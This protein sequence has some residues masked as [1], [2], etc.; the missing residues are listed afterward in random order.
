MLLPLSRRQRRAPPQLLPRPTTRPLCPKLGW[1]PPPLRVCSNG[2][3]PTVFWPCYVLFYIHGWHRCH[4]GNCVCTTTALCNRCKCIY[5]CIYVCMCSNFQNI[6]I[7]IFLKSFESLH[8]TV[9]CRKKK[10]PECEGEESRETTLHYH[11]YH[12]VRV[13]LVG[14]FPS[15]S[16]FSISLRYYLVPLYPKLPYL[17]YIYFL[18]A[19]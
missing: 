9:G 18:L 19:C 5:V 11:T 14:W 3:N 1:F 2:N 7:S 10:R 15:L 17:R 8:S 12:N 4:V 16:L 13:L 6:A